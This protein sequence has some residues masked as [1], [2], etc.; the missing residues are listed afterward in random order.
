MGNLQNV[1]KRQR[2]DSA[3][4][5]PDSY[6][7]KNKTADRCTP[8]IAKSAVSFSLPLFQIPFF[9]MLPNNMVRYL[10][11]QLFRSQARLSLP[12]VDLFCGH[13]MLLPVPA[14]IAVVQDQRLQVIHSVS[15]FC[16]RR[17]I[18]L[19]FIKEGNEQN[20]R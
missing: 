20:G 3:G 4:T 11:K 9:D 7:M 14:V 13:S 18:F 6:K 19:K 12:A 17:L 5:R 16:F 2:A 8:T 10:F 1:W 15:K